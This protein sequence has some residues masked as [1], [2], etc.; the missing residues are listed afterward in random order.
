MKRRTGVC[1]L[2]VMVVA[3]HVAAAGIR[4]DDRAAEVLAKVKLSSGGTAWDGVR[5][6]HVKAKFATGGLTGT[7]ESWEDILSGRAREGFAIGP[8]KGVEGFD[9]K[10]A[11]SQD[12]SGQANADEGEDT[13]LRVASEAYRRTMA[14]WYPERRKGAIEYAGEKDEG[15]RHFHILRITPEGGRGFQIW[16][17]AATWLIDRFVEKAALETRTTYFSDYRDVAGVKMAFATRLTNG[18]TRYDQTVTAVS[19]DINVPIDDAMF[20]M[21]A[22]A[23]KDFTIAGGQTSTAVPFTLVNGHI[24]LQVKLDGQGPFLF[25]CD[26]GGANIVTPELAKSLG[27][28]SAG[29]IQ[30]RGVGEKSE[31]V[32]LTKVRKL[33]V[34]EA[35]LADQV[36]AVYPMGG[37]AEAEGVAAQ[38][39]IGYEVF[40]R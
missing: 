11:W 31:D 14:Y 19:V 26:T 32:G 40:K 38:G 24:Y 36:F 9:G 29:A 18:E 21:P 6:I 5:S 13:R 12:T 35:S 28:A 7:A 34:G 23:P 17:D 4:A 20:A 16:V 8:M 2:A 22:A 37:L 10:T 27:L 33:E 30:G 39:L 15:G 1:F 25:M 3:I